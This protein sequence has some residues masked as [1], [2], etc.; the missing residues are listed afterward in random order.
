MP[1]FP[2]PESA[3]PY[4]SPFLAICAAHS[5]RALSVL[6]TPL[7]ALFLQVKSMREDEDVKA[8]RSIGDPLGLPDAVLTRPLLCLTFLQFLSKA[9]DPPK[10]DQLN[11]AWKTLV[12]LQAVEGEDS[13]SRLT[14]LGR[15]VRLPLNSVPTCASQ[16][17]LMSVLCR[18][19]Q[20]RSTCDWLRCSFLERSSA[21]STLSCRSRPSSPR[22]RSSFPRWTSAT[23]LKSKRC[24]RENKGR[25]SLTPA[26]AG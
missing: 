23:R 21:A 6:R 5:L 8:V 10:V 15:H 22:S 17:Q 26:S 11:A 25:Q 14:A 4:T 3:C 18:W 24:A 13:T 7:E 16:L 9:I 19:R 1:A 2:I 12:D 20:F